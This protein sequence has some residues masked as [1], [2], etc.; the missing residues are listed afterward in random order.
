MKSTFDFDELM[1]GNK[2]QIVALD[3]AEMMEIDGG[4]IWVAV[5]V[6]VA[7]IFVGWIM[8]KVLDGIVDGIRRDC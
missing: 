1:L 3:E 8:S 4:A 2:D 7:G 6:F 5:A